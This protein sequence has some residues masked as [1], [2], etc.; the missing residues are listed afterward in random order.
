[1]Q[2]WLN[3]WKI[4]NALHHINKLKKKEIIWQD[5]TSIHISKLN[6]E[7][8]LP[9]HGKGHL[10]KPSY[11]STLHGERPSAFSLGVGTGQEDLLALTTSLPALHFTGKKEAWE[12]MKG[13]WG[14]SH[15][16]S[17]LTNP[18]R[19]QE[20][21]G[22]IP[23]LAQW[24]KHLLLLWAVVTEVARIPSCCGCGIGQQL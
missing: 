11:K 8:K 9:R 24:V 18:T 23:G 2:S 17:V 6:E 19:I 12:E 13:I 1:M 21:A 14:S 15:R 16:G 5:S 7:R 10:Q 4:I 22:S 20:D 3:I